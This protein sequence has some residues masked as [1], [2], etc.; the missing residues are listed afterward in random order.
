MVHGGDHGEPGVVEIE[1]PPPEALVVVDDVEITLA[2]SKFVADANGE[3]PGLWKATREHRRD[4]E[5]IDRALDLSKSWPAEWVG[6]AVEVETRDL[7]ELDAHFE[8]GI[9]LTRK[10]RDGMASTRKFHAPDEDQ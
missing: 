7:H 6:F 5:R 2:S 1:D 10:D 3:G 4:L 8:L 9:G